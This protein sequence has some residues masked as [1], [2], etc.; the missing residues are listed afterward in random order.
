MIQQYN[1]LWFSPIVIIVKKNGVDIWL[2]II[3]RLVND[4]TQLIVYP[5]DLMIKLLADLEKA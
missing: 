5:M 4:L 3:Y 1:S 2:C